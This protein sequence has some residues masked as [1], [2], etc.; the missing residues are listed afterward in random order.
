VTVPAHRYLWSPHDENHGHY[1]RYD[2]AMLERIWKGRH[3]HPIFVSYFNFFLFPVIYAVRAYNRWRDKEWGE[4]G[5]D[6]VVP[7]L[8]LNGILESI[9][10]SEGAILDSL[11][12]RGRPSGF[13]IGVSLM[14][15]LRKGSK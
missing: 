3:V 5:T 13:P 8:W 9:F 1:R 10:S 11:L 15:L 12:K 4:A 14:A 2:K 6:L 7:K